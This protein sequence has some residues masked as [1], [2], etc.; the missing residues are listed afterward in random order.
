MSWKRKLGITV[1]VLVPLLLALGIFGAVLFARQGGFAPYRVPRGGRHDVPHDAATLEKGAYLAHLGNCAAC[2]TVRGGTPYAGG[3][4]IVTDYG[5]IY[6]TNITPN[7]AHG[8]GDWSLEEFAHTMRHGVSRRGV[9]YPAFPYAHFALLTDADIAALYAYLQTLA[10]S[11]AQA[12]DNELDFPASWRPSLIGWRMLFYRPPQGDA[13]ADRGRYLTDGLGHCAMCHS[14]RGEFGSLPPQGYLAGGIIP[15]V[16][17][18]A[19]PL[20]SARLQRYTPDEL[21]QFLRSGKTDAGDAYG[22]MAEAIY[23]GLH[24][25]SADDAGA[26]AR[27]LQ[28]LPPHAVVRDTPVPAPQ[29]VRTQAVDGSAVYRRVCSDCH[30]VDGEG[31]PG[32]YPALRDAVAVSVPEPVNAVRMVLYGGLPP[33]TPLN[34]QPYSMPPFVYQL[35]REEIAAVVNYVRQQFGHRA[36]TLSGA[37]IEPLEGIVLE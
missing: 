4:A 29:P 24:A 28:S 19:P 1:I 12:P 17:W 3:R 35:K 30:G 21:A 10:P 8:I 18:Y 7:A 20:D 11:N 9:L 5:R 34:P 14:R 25:L 33:T 22:P 13:S 32:K 16:R 27:Y 31:T 2:H 15:S 23:D 37:D 6:S 26:I 36:S